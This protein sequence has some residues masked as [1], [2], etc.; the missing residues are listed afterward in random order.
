MLYP[1][2]NS[3]DN[4]VPTPPA[5][6]GQCPLTPTAPPP[7]Y[8]D[9]VNGQY[10]YYPV[11]QVAPAPTLSEQGCNTDSTSISNTS[12]TDC[13]LFKRRIKT[14]AVVVLMGFAGMGGL[15]AT[16]ALSPFFGAYIVGSVL[17]RGCFFISL[18]R[19][20]SKVL[21]IV[22]LTAIAVASLPVIIVSP[23]F[24]LAAANRTG[25]SLWGNDYHPPSL[26]EWADNKARY[27]LSA[28]CLRLWLGIPVRYH[29]CGYNDRQIHVH[30]HYHTHHCWTAGG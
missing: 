24:A 25:K 10:H 23:V 13:S 19:D 11:N 18:D 7:S 12:P 4:L 29:Q 14:F 3:G 15:L 30:N 2:I 26:M 20:S 5:G 8:D 22:L 28:D 1:P 17:C 27:Y 21:G 16:I 9:V 6:F